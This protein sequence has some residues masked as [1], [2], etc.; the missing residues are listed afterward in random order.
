MTKR[1]PSLSRRLLF[2]TFTFA[3]SAA[4]L[5]PLLASCG[6][7]EEGPDPVPL[8]GTFRVQIGER[9]VDVALRDGPVPSDGSAVVYTRAYEKDGSPVLTIEP[10]EGRAS[11]PKKTS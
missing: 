3:L 9:T 2:R 1:Q 10:A 11:A 6:K 7:E 5:L 8:D 4:L